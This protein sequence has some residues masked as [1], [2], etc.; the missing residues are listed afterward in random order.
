VWAGSNWLRRAPNLVN[1]IKP[2]RNGGVGGGGVSDFLD[3][4]SG[5]HFLKKSSVALICSREAVCIY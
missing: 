2:F 3:Q 5:F 4:L 1:T